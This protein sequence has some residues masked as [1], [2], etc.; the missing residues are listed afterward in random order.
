MACHQIGR[1]GVEFGPNLGEIGAKLGKEALYDAIV[2][3]SSG[4][5]FG[6]EA[7]LLTMRDGDEVLGLIA[8]ETDQEVAVKVPGGQVLRYRKAEIVKRD[9]QAQSI[10]P[11]GMQE[12]LSAQDFADLLT[13]LSSLKPR[14]P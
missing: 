12:A 9:K 5:S 6:F 8:S 1:E 13:Y 7:W 2:E 4:I 3:P 11:A 14:S 10:M